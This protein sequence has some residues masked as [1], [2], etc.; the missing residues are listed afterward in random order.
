MNGQRLTPNV[1][2]RLRAGDSF[3]VGDPANVLRVELG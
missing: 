1:P 2:Y 3:Y